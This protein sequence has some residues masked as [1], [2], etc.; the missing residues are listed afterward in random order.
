MSNRRFGFVTARFEV[1]RYQDTAGE[2][3]DD[4]F[5]QSLRVPVSIGQRQ[6]VREF[7]VEFNPCFARDKVDIEVMNSETEPVG[8]GAN[9]GGARFVGGY[10]R[11][12]MNDCFGIA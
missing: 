4:R 8:Y 1:N 5:F 12:D 6:G 3:F 10:R 9:A 7:Q 11:F 2:L